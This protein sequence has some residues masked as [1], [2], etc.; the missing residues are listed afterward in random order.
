MN[1]PFVE[2]TL[3]DALD[4]DLV[5]FLDL[6]AAGVLLLVALNAGCGTCMGGRFGRQARHLAYTY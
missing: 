6:A 1:A 3:T 4:D 5:F 2:T